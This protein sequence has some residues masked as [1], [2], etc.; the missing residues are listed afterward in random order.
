MRSQSP[1]SFPSKNPTATEGRGLLNA[2]Y[3]IVVGSNSIMYFT[4]FKQKANRHWSTLAETRQ[5]QCSENDSEAMQ[6]ESNAD[7][8]RNRH[9]IAGDWGNEPPPPATK[10]KT[11]PS[12]P[13]SFLIPTPNPTRPISRKPFSSPTQVPESSKATILELTQIKKKKKGR[14]R[15]V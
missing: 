10:F 8:A 13:R 3:W 2:P 7:S 12:I 11:S 15:T 6:K 14:A 4:C 9:S 1:H 5:R